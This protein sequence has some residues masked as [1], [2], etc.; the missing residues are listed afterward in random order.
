[1]V[2]SSCNRA[3][4]TMLGQCYASGEGIDRNHAEAVRLYN[5]AADN[6]HAQAQ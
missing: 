1:M 6:G 4:I 2:S 5:L 3:A